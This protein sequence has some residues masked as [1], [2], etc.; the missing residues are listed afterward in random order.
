[1]DIE[2]VEGKYPGRAALLGEL[3]D[4]LNYYLKAKGKE[5]ERIYVSR[6][7]LDGLSELAKR[8]KLALEPLT[9]RDIPLVLQ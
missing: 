5:P 7:K 2:R 3:R 6:K 9:F 4:F 8:D 1:M